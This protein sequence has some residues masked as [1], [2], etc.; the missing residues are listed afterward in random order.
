[1]RNLKQV[2]CLGTLFCLFLV[3]WQV[4]AAQQISQ[5]TLPGDRVFPEGI[6]LQASTGD[7][8]VSNTTDGS[9]LKGNIGQ[10]SA[11]T[12]IT[13][14]TEGLT[15]TR[16]LKVDNQ[17]RLF[18]AAGPQGQIFVFNTADRRLVNKF[19]T[20]VTPSFVNDVTITPD[21]RAYFTDSQSP[22]IYRVQPGDGGALNFERWLDVSPTISYVQGF[23]L[24]GI[25]HSADGRY[26]VVA[27]G[28]VGKLYRIEVASKAIQEIN[29]GG[30]DVRN[31]DGI[32]LDG[33][34]LYVMRNAEKTLVALEMTNNFS[35]GRAFFNQAVAELA[36]PTTFA[37]NGSRLL[38]VNGQFDKRAGTPTLPFTVASIPAPAPAGG[39]QGGV[40]PGAPASGV[41]GA[42]N[43][44]GNFT[45][46]ALGT[47]LIVGGVAGGLLVRRRR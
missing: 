3:S 38:V 35:Q 20:G 37:K 42:I 31:A 44:S 27:Q 12:W 24:G 18:A 25:A 32:L 28:N 21:G 11:S 6:A 29:L 43:L 33:N 2:V 30:A 9:I 17:G 46:L 45:W 26:L 39:G 15:G 47:L 36:F 7:F 13:G 1:M 10:A 19:S 22:N 41:G 14:A 8:Y 34:I 16:G 23:N 40:Q 4:V 5:Y